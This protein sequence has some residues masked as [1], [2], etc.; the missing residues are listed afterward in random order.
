MGLSGFAEISDRVICFETGFTPKELEKS[1]KELSEKVSFYKEWI[2]VK[3]LSKYD[4][5]KGEQNNLWKAYQKEIDSVPE[6]IR[7]ILQ[8]PSKGLPSP[9]PEGN[10]IG[11]VMV[12]ERVIHNRAKN[13]FED[14]TD[15]FIFE[16]AKNKNISHK[17]AKQ[18]REDLKNYCDE[19]GPAKDW[20]AKYRTFVNNAIKWDKSLIQIIPQVAI[21]VDDRTP[22]EIELSKLKISQMRS[23]YNKIG[24]IPS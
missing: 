19:N 24:S 9:L 22:E 23:Q 12:K 20:K 21:P 16:V 7:K 13:S 17:T 1:K 10:G 18:I 14:L 11:K 3:N 8:D 6:K 15:E 5:I 4:P 2:Y